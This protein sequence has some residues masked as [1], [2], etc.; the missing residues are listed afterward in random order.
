MAGLFKKILNRFTNTAE[1]DWD[2]LEADLVAGD[3]GLPLTTKIIND[4]RGQGRTITGR[5]VVDTSRKHLSRL[6]PEDA[7]PLKPGTDGLPTVVLVV[8]INGTGKTT[9][10]AKLGHFLTKQG[11]SV[12]LAAADTFRAA[13]TE[14]LVAWAERLELPVVTGAPQADPSSVCYTAHKHAIE[15]KADFLICDTAGR[16]HTRH[17]LMEELSKIRRTIAKQDPVAPHRTLLVID[18]TTGANGLSQTREFQKA[19]T[20]DGLILTKLDGSGK[21]GVAAAIYQDAK[22]SP[23]FIGTG[24]EPEAFGPFRRDEF[25]N[26]I[27]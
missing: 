4:L 7:E 20:L 12:M 21:G 5:D 9:S 13:A 8:G 22:I 23:H 19:V 16:L 26:K 25:V 27:L 14:Q 11:H 10:V 2:D 6:F 1:I 15:R 18:A 3:L 24:E 17:N